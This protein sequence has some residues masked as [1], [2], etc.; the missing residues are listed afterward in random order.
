MY[1]YCNIDAE[2][3]MRRSQGRIWYYYVNYVILLAFLLIHRAAVLARN[4]FS[5]TREFAYIVL[6]VLRI[7]I[8]VRNAL[9]E[10]KAFKR[11]IFEH[12]ASSPAT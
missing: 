5:A 3:L 4:S 6:F 7:F 8:S 2:N 9:C 11:T 10:T 12:V 1:G